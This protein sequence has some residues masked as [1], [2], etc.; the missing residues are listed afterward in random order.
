MELVRID[1]HYIDEL[2]KIDN[3]VQSNSIEQS[4]QNKPF[5][6]SCLQ[7]KKNN[8]LYF[9]PLSSPK[10][11]H[12]KMKNSTDFHKVISKDGKLRAVINFNNMIPVDKTLYS[13]IDI[14]KDKDKY[15]LYD[16]YLFCRDN[17]QELMKK[18]TILYNRY[19]HGNLSS[20]EQSRTCDF[21]KLEQR[22]QTY[23]IEIN[24]K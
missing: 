1:T 2:R 13:R 22:L 19:I 11:K 14:S 15:V 23:L 5:W 18:A 8:F 12:E 6:A 21:K 9:A 17:E 16:E 3:R 7:L 4:K 10:P 24:S 20:T